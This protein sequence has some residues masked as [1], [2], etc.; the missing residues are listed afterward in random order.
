MK[1]FITS[2]LA[3]SV[4]A[5]PDC[6]TNEY[7]FKNND[8]FIDV[9]KLEMIRREE[10]YCVRTEGTMKLFYSK[11]EVVYLSEEYKFCRWSSGLINAK[12]ILDENL[13]FKTQYGF[14]TTST[15]RQTKPKEYDSVVIENADSFRCYSG[16]G[17]SLS[18]ECLEEN[19]EEENEKYNKLILPILKKSIGKTYTADIA[20]DVS[21][22]KDS[23]DTNYTE[24][25]TLKINRPVVVIGECH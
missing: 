9:V 5:F 18:V 25:K 24:R 20:I 2:I 17:L 14:L 13:T 22:L 1:L 7:C 4:F 8:P 23:N 3:F 10:D 21:C 19:S 12:V 16:N 6:A 11:E 15:G